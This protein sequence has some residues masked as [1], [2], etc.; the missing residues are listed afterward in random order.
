M[1]VMK[2]FVGDFLLCMY[3]GAGCSTFLIFES[4][5]FLIISQ[6]L[7]HWHPKLKLSVDV[8]KGG[9]QGCMQ[10]S[11]AVYYETMCLVALQQSS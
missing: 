9:A 11:T 10:H 7:P 4:R 1:V 3:K 2:S 5:L 8:R 6:C